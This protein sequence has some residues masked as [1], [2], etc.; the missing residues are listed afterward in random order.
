GVV[1][2]SPAFFTKEWP[3]KE[4]DGLVT[5]EDGRGK[6]ILPIWHKVTAIDIGRFSPIL[7]DKLAISTNRGLAVVANSILHAVNNSE[8]QANPIQLHA[9]NR[10]RELLARLRTQMLTAVSS[11]E[12]R[13]TVYELDEHLAKYPHSPEARLLKDQM[14]V[15][16]KHAERYERPMAAASP[17]RWLVAIIVAILSFLLLYLA[18]LL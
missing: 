10:E 8:D 11:W 16:M 5:R 14:V 9:F 12:L 1:I 3:N 17:V 18:L 2:L 15:A 13:Q 6:V 4:L 7:A